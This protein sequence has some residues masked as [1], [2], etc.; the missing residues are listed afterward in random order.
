MSFPE[1]ITKTGLLLLLLSSLQCT[2]EARTASTIACSSR[3]EVPISDDILNIC[4]T[5]HFTSIYTTNLHP[6]HTNDDWY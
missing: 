2:P 5:V 6:T 1:A 4:V 3:I